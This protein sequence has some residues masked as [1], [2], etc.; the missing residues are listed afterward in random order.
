[1]L[2]NLSQGTASVGIAADLQIKKR[3]TA[4]HSR[5][6]SK[7]RTKMAKSVQKSLCQTIKTLSRRIVVVCIA[8]DLQIQERSETDSAGETS[9]IRPEM[10]IFIRK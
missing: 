7:I 8:A 10:A 4:D 2:G 1:M 6:T 3:T 5:E 9:K